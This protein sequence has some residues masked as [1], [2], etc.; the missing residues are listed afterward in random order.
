M[1]KNNDVQE[2]FFTIISLLPITSDTKEV[3]ELVKR[4]IGCITIL[5]DADE[6]N[7]LI[8]TNYNTQDLKKTPLDVV[9]TFNFH[10][11]KSINNPQLLKLAEYI[12]QAGGKKQAD[13]FLKKLDDHIKIVTEETD[14]YK[15]I[16]ENFS[17]EVENL[18]K[19]SNFSVSE[20]K[21][22]LSTIEEKK[23]SFNNLFKNYL[24]ESYQDFKFLAYQEKS[25][26][27][28]EFLLLCG[29]MSFIKIE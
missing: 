2:M 24:K 3:D 18:Q 23:E 6:I 28:D 11:K 14:E 5:K 29:K 21:K 26:I 13:F 4:A 15:K 16:F 1:L 22:L 7:S 20:L 17:K 8:T 19:S 10:N 9:F 27:F 12:K 25:P